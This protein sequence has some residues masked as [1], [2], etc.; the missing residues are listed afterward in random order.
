MRVKRLRM[1]L[2][3]NMMTTRLRNLDQ[4]KV[5]VH[6]AIIQTNIPSGSGLNPR[7]QGLKP[8]KKLVQIQCVCQAWEQ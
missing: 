2:K 6:E 3:L 7:P 4:V 1:S 5:S 8:E